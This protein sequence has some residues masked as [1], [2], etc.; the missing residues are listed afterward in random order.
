MQMIADHTKTTAELKAMAPKAGVELPTAMDSSHQ[1][2]V[3]KLKGLNGAEFDKEYD[4]MQV[5]AHEDAV[6]LFG[7]YAEGGENPELK[8]WAGK[9]LPHLKHHLEM[10]KALRR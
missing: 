6:S 2:K 10:A 4:S 1:S 5:E 7:R 8:A 3:E 9:T